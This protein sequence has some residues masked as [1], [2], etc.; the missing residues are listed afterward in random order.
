MEAR[1]S[2]NLSFAEFLQRMVTLAESSYGMVKV[3]FLK[4]KKFTTISD[5]TEIR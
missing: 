4:K 2:I 1:S 3:Y 5:K